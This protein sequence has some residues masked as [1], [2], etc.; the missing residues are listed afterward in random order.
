MYR[1]SLRC[2]YFFAILSVLCVALGAS[3]FFE[4]RLPLRCAECLCVDSV[5]KSFGEEKS[6]GLVYVKFTLTNRESHPIRVIGASSEC[7]QQGCLT[8]EGLPLEIPANTAQTINVEVIINSRGS[9][10]KP[11]SIYTDCKD[12]PDFVVWVEGRVI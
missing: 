5:R 11:M 4:K 6:G 8:V 2:H 1:F 3:A 7:T 12:K 9:F 10:S